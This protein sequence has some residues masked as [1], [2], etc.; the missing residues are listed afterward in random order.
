MS[1]FYI[2]K[3]DWDR[4]INYARAREQECGDEI[5]GMAVIVK[6]KDDDYLIKQPVIL[7]QETT[8]ATCTLDKDELAQ[9]YSD[10]AHKY[11]NNVQFLW[12]H[13]HAKMG[14]FWSGTDTNTMT[15]YKNS[16][17]SAFLVV[18]VREEYKFRVQYWQPYEMGEDIDLNIL[19]SKT[20]E[21][22]IPKN[23]LNDI[24]DKCCE[25]TVVKSNYSGYTRYNHV[26]QANLWQNPNV[27]TKDTEL[28]S[29]L[30]ELETM[31][32]CGM[33][34][35]GVEVTIQEEPVAYL[36]E[37]LEM[38]N[39]KYCE[40]QISYAKYAKA[41]NEFNDTLRRLEGPNS[42]K[43]RVD[44]YSENKLLDKCM[45]LSPQDFITINTKPITD[46]LIER[47]SCSQT[48]QY[49]K[50]FNLGDVI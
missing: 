10:M 5:G 33:N 49:N 7:K 28:D 16:H 46:L 43:L 24:K 27:P 31:V 37:Q 11:G 9:Y 6:D 14:A 34:Y 20:K 36:I 45:E 29:L 25:K 44:L 19:T 13:S 2:Q 32:D 35:Y 18:N 8:G 50:G 41:V 42:P 17:W 22:A 30:D 12:W 47:E 40:G 23:I 39:Q 21:R 26:G 48:E 15:E 1:D 38:G 4:I 3:K